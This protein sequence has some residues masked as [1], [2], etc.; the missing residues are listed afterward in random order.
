MQEINGLLAT[1]DIRPAGG[2]RAATPQFDTTVQKNVAASIEGN[3][4]Y[5]ALRTRQEKQA[6]E[7][8]LDARASSLINDYIVYGKNV[9]LGENGALYQKGT[10]V[11]NGVNGESWVSF[12][13]GKLR[14]K[15]DSILSSVEGNKRLYEKVRAGLEKQDV[16]FYSA[17]DS[18]YG[19]E[20]LN[21][22][23]DQNTIGLNN[24]LAA[25]TSGGATSQRIGAVRTN[26]ATLARLN[27]RNV[28]D[29]VY[30]RAFG[31]E[32]RAKVSAATKA[33][34]T[35]RLGREDTNGADSLYMM[36]VRN[37][38]FTAN[39]QLAV[40][41]Q[42]KRVKDARF[43]ADAASNITLAATQA[44]M[45]T[46][47]AARSVLSSGGTFDASLLSAAGL[48]ANK[49]AEDG[50][51]KNAA[52]TESVNAQVMGALVND[53][54]TIDAAIAAATVGKDTLESAVQ[55][56][57]AKGDLT[58][59]QAELS[60]ADKAR[61]T[62]AINRYQNDVGRRTTPDEEELRKRVAQMYPDAPSDQRERIVSAAKTR[63]VEETVAR[64]A[65]QAAAA[66]NLVSALSSGQEPKPADLSVLSPAQ[67]AAVSIIKGRQRVQN[68]PSDMAFYTRIQNPQTLKSMS[69]ADFV[70]LGQAY[71]SPDDYAEAAQRRNML[72]GV[73]DVD[74]LYVTRDQ[75]KPAVEAIIAAKDPKYNETPDGKYT[76]NRTVDLVRHKVQEAANARGKELTRA[77]IDEIV[78]Q[79]LV[80]DRFFVPPGFFGSGEYKSV[81]SLTVGD[82]SSTAKDLA[83][84]MAKAQY[85][86]AF[87]DDAAVLS[88]FKEFLLFPPAELPENVVDKAK[89]LYGREIDET[90]NKFLTE[91]GSRLSDTAAIRLTLYV[92][93]QDPKYFEALR[94]KSDTKYNSVTG[95]RRSVL[96]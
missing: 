38:M 64:S 94:D 69:D 74:K 87:P 67:V 80:G 96:Y 10:E 50:Y 24:E 34:I 71:L 4:R 68:P 5:A 21:Y 60:P 41:A 27:G 47:V 63:I 16:G 14:E 54:G 37:G 77:E 57:E 6:E 31:E 53:Y 9:M 26:M 93:Q 55:A 73:K 51:G 62:T 91:G 25:I 61:V 70:L 28:K 76:F 42:I 89:A 83:K 90:R 8:M 92:L 84:E 52:V 20:S 56:A 3:I 30:A 88:A 12:N 45:P 22:V 17:L 44:R 32:V 95:E 86:D 23:K 33:G 65:Q 7:D 39:D 40:Q 19:Q 72:K 48:D 2:L 82:L 29:P 81:Y 18:H 59:W 79:T 13:Q 78:G 66:D 58:K 49:V 75:V 43:E 35:L 15:R 46:Y 85:G 11:V 1:P 36:A